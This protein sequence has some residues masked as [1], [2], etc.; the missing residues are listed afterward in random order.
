MKK[1]NL[2]FIMPDQFRAD[3]LPV[4]GCHAIATPHLNELAAQ[5]THCL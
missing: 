4:Y 2:I 1:P 5:S 3:F